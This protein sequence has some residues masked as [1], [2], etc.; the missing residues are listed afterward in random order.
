MSFS[1]L[2]TDIKDSLSKEPTQ[3]AITDLTS[4]AEKF[5]SAIDSYVLSL[6]DPAQR[7]PLTPG[8]TL[9][10]AGIISGMLAPNP[11]GTAEIPAVLYATAISSYVTAIQIDSSPIQ[12]A[13][14]GITV[15]PGTVTTTKLADLGVFISIKNDFVEIFTEENPVELTIQLLTLLKATKF[16]NAIKKAIIDKTFITISG[17]DSTIPTP[18]PFSLTGQFS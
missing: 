6:K 16:A 15:P 10:S 12:L 1:S 17:N 18:I 9:I 4:H 3:V 14:E 7:P 8:P 2:I 5:A 11:T 13:L